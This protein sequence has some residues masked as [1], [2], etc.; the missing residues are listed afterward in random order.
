M[1]HEKIFTLLSEII[2]GICAYRDDLHIHVDDHGTFA[3]TL[4]V[5]PHMADYRKLVGRKGC[6]IDALKIFAER[7]G[8]SV[9]LSLNI[10]LQETG[11]GAP[12]PHQHIESQEFDHTTF[13]RLVRETV[14]WAFSRPLTVEFKDQWKITVTIDAPIDKASQDNLLQIARIFYPYGRANGREVFIRNA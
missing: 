13:E 10:E 12:E 8:S 11:I 2:T 4:I 6:T 14:E 5:R 1:K 7:A 9:G 3:K